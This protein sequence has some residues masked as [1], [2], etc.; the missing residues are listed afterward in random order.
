[1]KMKLSKTLI[2]TVIS[3]TLILTN[4]VIV[5]AASISDISYSYSPKII[6]ITNDYNLKDYL[7]NSSSGSLNIAD[8]TKSHYFL[9]Y[10]K[11]IDIT[12]ESIAIEIMGHVYPDKIARYLPWG[13]GDLIIKHTNII[14]IGETSVDSNRWVWDSIAAVV[15]NN[16]KSV[17]Y[18]KNLVPY[19]MSVEQ[20]VD[21]IIKNSKGKNLKLNKEIMIKV[22]KDIDNGNIDPMLLKII[23]K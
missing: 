20:H 3:F 4:T 23:E 21:M 5:F 22:Q 6:H 13:L 16:F 12:R 7:S 9:K 2:V 11:E 10:K 17:N 19:K 14:D 1:M 8:Y 18:S 15:G